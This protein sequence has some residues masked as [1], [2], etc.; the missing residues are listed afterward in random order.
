MMQS[1][2]CSSASRQR[3]AAAVEFALCAM[4]FFSFVFGVIE[5]A[6]AMYLWSTMVEVTQRGGRLASKA[7]FADTGELTAVRET[8]F[9]AGAAGGLPLRGDLSEN[10]L[11][12]EYL[13]HDL[14]PVSPMPAC[15]EENIVNC[16]TNPDSASCIRFVRVRLCR[17][18]SGATCTRVDYVPLVGGA[19]FPAGTLLFPTFTT[20]TP[21]ASLGI[22]PGFASGSC[23]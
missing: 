23:P 2:P 14:T 9:F 8:A 6:R 15:P 21:V 16:S 4:L 13:A 20:I 3:G 12:I 22:Q 17:E 11:L 18:S 5:L 1:T 10:N 19:F 7:N